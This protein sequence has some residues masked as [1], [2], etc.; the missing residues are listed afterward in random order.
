MKNLLLSTL[1]LMLCVAAS[2]LFA[3]GP[4]CTPD[5]QF[6]VANGDFG[7]YPEPYQA[8]ITSPDSSGIITKA[9]E[10]D[11][12][13]YVFT[14][15]VPDS[16]EFSGTMVPLEKVTL[17]PFPDGVYLDAG[18]GY[19]ALS[20]VGL[21][22]Q[23]D[24]PS[25]EFLKLTEGCAV[26]Y[27]NHT[28]TAGVYPTQIYAEAQSFVALAVT[29]PDPT[30]FPGVY[31]LTV[32]P[33]SDPACTI[34][35]DNV[36]EINLGIAQNSP[37]PF[38]GNTTI[39]VTSKINETF[40]FSVYSQNGSLVETREVELRMGDNTIEFDGSRLGAGV[41]FYSFEFEGQRSVKRMVVAN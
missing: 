35:V 30:L 24:P 3:Q 23:C 7:V 29:F 13:E 16:I 31:D 26:I 15:V 22:Y 33:A 41:Y 12:F 28:L 14:A 20:N 40:S 39:N 10:G 18:S 5:P 4:G 9:C 8:G 19:A 25:C 6:S 34:S 32:L 2:P 21:S 1:A 38:R 36:V 11:Y 37:N 27:G 17:D